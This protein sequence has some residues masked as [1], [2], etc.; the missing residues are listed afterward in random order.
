MIGSLARSLARP[1][2][3]P[4]K[5]P[6][7]D[8]QAVP[9]PGS[10]E[11]E[12]GRSPVADPKRVGAN[13][14]AQELTPEDQREVQRLQARDK[15][16]RAHEQ[17][18][19]AAGGSHAGAPSYE[20]ETGP[21]GKRYAV[22]GEVAIDTSVDSGDPTASIS[23]LEQVVRAA[24]APASPSGQDR[25]VAAQAQAKIARM[26]AEMIQQEPEPLD[27]DPERAQAAEAYQKTSAGDESMSTLNLVA[28]DSCG[29]GHAP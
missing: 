22:G 21:D 7:S 23:K 16:V 18:H 20:Y 29:S 11:S 9:E 28:C 27:G 10:V 6:P 19:A 5:T 8:P 25:K 14:A 3:A 4:Q 26:R 13:E 12:P 1:V 24:L 17:A 15:E 2:Q